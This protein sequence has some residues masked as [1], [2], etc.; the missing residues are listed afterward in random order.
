VVYG[1]LL[2]ICTLVQAN[3]PEKAGGS[4]FFPAQFQCNDFAEITCK[5]EWIGEALNKQLENLQIRS[6]AEDW[7]RR[8]ELDRFQTDN[9]WIN[10]ERIEVTGGYV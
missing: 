10:A 7:L 1:Q 8:P 6:V 3:A 5:I 4:A 2:K 9:R